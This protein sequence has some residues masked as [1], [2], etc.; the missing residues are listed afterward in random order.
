MKNNDNFLPTVAKTAPSTVEF[1]T[2]FIPWPT[3]DT[4]R[5]VSATPVVLS[6]SN[7]SNRKE[8]D[9]TA[10]SMP[11]VTMKRFVSSNP[12]HQEYQLLDYNLSNQQFEEESFLLICFLVV[13]VAA[14]VITCVKKEDK[15]SSTTGEEDVDMLELVPTIDDDDEHEVISEVRTIKTRSKSILVG[16]IS[17]ESKCAVNKQ[18]AE[19]RV[20]FEDEK[21]KDLST[22]PTRYNDC[23]SLM[24]Y[25]SNNSFQDMVSN[26]I[27]KL[28]LDEP[29]EK[30]DVS[31][32]MPQCPITAAEKKEEQHQDLIDVS[33][34]T[35]NKSED[36][37]S[38]SLDPN[39]VREYEDFLFQISHSLH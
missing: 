33:S 7:E 22:V 18:K 12:T 15:L 6:T 39:M 1:R 5:L 11:L 25:T 21:D 24:Q 37:E 34:T 35:P 31:A 29:V 10:P 26:E 36:E 30:C 9:Y 3:T 38:C 14:Y 17:S 4:L 8:V 20:H 2:H 28:L 16:S 32:A 19:K 27:L 23:K 13:S